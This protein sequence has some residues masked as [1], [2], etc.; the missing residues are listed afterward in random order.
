M[1]C[2]INLV[3]YCLYLETRIWIARTWTV[4]LGV[5]KN[6]NLLQSLGCTT[7]N[8]IEYERIVELTSLTP[9]LHGSTDSWLFRYAFNI[10]P[11]ERITILDGLSEAIITQCINCDIK[12]R[13]RA[14]YVQ[15]Q[16][17]KFSHYYNGRLESLLLSSFFTP[18]K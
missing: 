12:N 3:I 13:S 16:G 11:T 18:F 5:T 15:S 10:N 8:I 17:C 7:W 9:R 4:N 2:F 1:L 14:Y 6:Y